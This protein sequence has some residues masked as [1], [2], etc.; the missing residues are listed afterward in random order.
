[1]KNYINKEIKTYLNIFDDFLMSSE[2][3]ELESHPKFGKL[4]EDFMLAYES[5]DFFNSIGEINRCCLECKNLVA[6]IT[7][8]IL[9][10]IINENN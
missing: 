9:P 3:S 5:V 8:E 7:G 6:F 1:M 10:L 4:L 2:F